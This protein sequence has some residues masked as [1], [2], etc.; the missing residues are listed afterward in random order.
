MRIKFKI[1]R[2]G[3][4]LEAPTLGILRTTMHP[5]AVHLN[6]GAINGCVSGEILPRGSIVYLRFVLYV[7]KI[8]VQVL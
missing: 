1:T 2:T 3:E 8:Y 5:H 7:H 6:P 4:G